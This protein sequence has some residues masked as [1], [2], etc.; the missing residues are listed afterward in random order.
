[1]H[2][3]ISFLK[4]KLAQGKFVFSS[5]SPCLVISQ[6]ISFQTTSHPQFPPLS[7]QEWHLV[8]LP[9]FWSKMPDDVLSHSC[10]FL[11]CCLSNISAMIKWTE[12]NHPGQPPL[13]SIQL[14]PTVYFP[15]L[16]PLAIIPTDG[17]SAVWNV[18]SEPP[19]HLN[20]TL[21]ANAGFE[22]QR[23]TFITSPLLPNDWLDTFTREEVQLPLFKPI[24]Y[25][26]IILF[27]GMQDW[28]KLFITRRW[29]DNALH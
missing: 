9:C 25:K 3:H 1:M 21:K 15:I 5:S 13:T 11:R 24:A 18:Q 4:K 7:W 20:A 29:V 17:W 16:R 27:L 26:P 2:L 8:W 12:T 14:L 22:V 19:S 10:G 6:G 23:I 28:N